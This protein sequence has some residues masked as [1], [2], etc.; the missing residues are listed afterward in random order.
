MAVPKAKHHSQ[1]KTNMKGIRLS[2]RYHGVW[3]LRADLHVED[4]AEALDLIN[5]HQVEQRSRLKEDRVVLDLL[6]IL[7]HFFNRLRS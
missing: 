4:G 1:G 3:M 2:R 6:A 7:L 5:D